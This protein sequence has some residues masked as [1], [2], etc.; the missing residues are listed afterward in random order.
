MGSRG[1]IEVS[2]PL[3]DDGVLTEIGAYNEDAGVFI[4]KTTMRPYKGWYCYFLDSWIFRC[5]A[6][7][8]FGGEKI[9]T[10]LIR[11]VQTGDST[12][13]K[14]EKVIKDAVKTD[15]QIEGQDWI[16]KI[17]DMKGDKES[18]SFLDA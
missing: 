17:R 6:T 8:A 11:D 12:K 16:L 2:R 1:T 9:H 7:P 13:M 3:G 10:L 14:I 4:V 15:E 5:F 18:F